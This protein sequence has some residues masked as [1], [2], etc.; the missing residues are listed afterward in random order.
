MQYLEF[1]IGGLAALVL[2]I[3]YWRSRQET[4]LPP[5]KTIFIRTL[6]IK[7]IFVWAIV[8]PDIVKLNHNFSS[9]F[10]LHSFSAA[11]GLTAIAVALMR[12]YRDSNA[13]Y[14]AFFFTNAHILHILTDFIG[15]T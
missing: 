10:N 14:F 6:P 2:S 1:A 15:K 4:S 11:L 13:A 9:S 8:G 5:I 12:K 7:I 3:C